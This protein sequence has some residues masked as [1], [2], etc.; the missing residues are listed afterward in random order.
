ML[1][2]WLAKRKEKQ[3]KASYDRGYVFGMQRLIEMTA[4]PNIVWDNIQH[5]I[6]DYPSYHPFDK[7]MV[8]ALTDYTKIYR[9]LKDNGK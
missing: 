4:E 6:L 3:K 1:S 5:Y 7:G 9:R 8:D 2:K